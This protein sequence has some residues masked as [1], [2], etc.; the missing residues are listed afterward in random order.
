MTGTLGSVKHHLLAIGSANVTGNSPPLSPASHAGPG[1]GTGGSVFFSDG[2]S[3]VRLTMDESSP[4]LIQNFGSSAVLTLDSP[5]GPE[6]V[7]G[8]VEVVG[9]H[10]PK[11]AYLTINEGCIFSCRYCNV[12]TLDKHIKTPDEVESLIFDAIKRD[13]I[14]CISL[15]SGVIGTFLEEEDRLFAILERVR[16]FG[17]PVGV[18]VYPT[19]GL[20]KKLYDYGVVEV[21]F[22]LE[23][24]TDD[25]FAEMCPGL[26]RQLIVDS[27][28]EA[29]RVFGKN[30]VYS[31]I[32]LGLG[33][34]E[35]EMRSCI[36]QCLENGI[37]PVIRPLTP[38]A[39][40]AHFRR[41]PADEIFRVSGFLR[42]ELRRFGFAPSNLT[43]CEKCAGCDLAP[44]TDIREEALA[45]EC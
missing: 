7:V 15:T 13:R 9:C 33:E 8:F 5:E 10:C 22:N 1:L 11:Q 14:E 3:R 30:R 28:R 27:L 24:A 35:A 42:S 26:N 2:L 12:P 20:A 32:I 31:N 38:S 37:I 41:P 25:L 36:T 19:P 34:S 21:K 4:V 43:M 44:M 23:T 45:N 39:G 17:L 40:L 16:R 29:V 18:S 6:S